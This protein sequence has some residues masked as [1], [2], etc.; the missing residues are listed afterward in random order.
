GLARMLDE[1]AGAAAL[2]TGRGADELTEHA[3]RDLLEPAAAPTTR[4]GR[5]LC[6]RLDAV[7]TARRAGHGDLNRHACGRAARRVDE[8]HPDLRGDVP[9]TRR[10]PAHARAEQVVPEEGAE[11]VA[12][13]TEVEV[14][15]REAARSQTGM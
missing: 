7:A 9:T 11:E 10:G 1:A 15:G 14:P 6:A 3:A 12:D 8:L 2:R 5:H 4:A 13:V